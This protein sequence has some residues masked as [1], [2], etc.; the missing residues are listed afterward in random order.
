MIPTG[1]VARRATAPNPMGLGRWGMEEFVEP[2][3][4]RLVAEHL[5]LGVEELAAAV[6]LRDEL[7]ADS[8]D[9]VE[10]AMALEAEFAIVVPDRILDQVRSYGDLVDATGLLVR[11]RG[12]AETC[13][14]KSPV[15]IWARLVPPTHASS[16]R[17]E[18]ADW[19]TPYIAETIAAAALRAGVGA[20]LELT[21]AECANDGLARVRNQFAQLGGRG[22]QVIVRCDDR[23]PHIRTTANDEPEQPPSQRQRP[24]PAIRR[25]VTGVTARFP[26]PCGE[27]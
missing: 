22:V 26:A 25:E 2:R 8:L 4:R 6:S 19:L 20:R 1:R 18:Y 23:L 27:T 3:V 14:T 15:R 5:G 10:L 12:E 17:L 16:G 21:V 13:E 9:L 11:A 7:A 24:G